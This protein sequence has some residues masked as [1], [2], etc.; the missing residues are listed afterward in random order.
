MTPEEAR[1]YGL[2][3]T[4]RAFDQTYEVAGRRFTA[5]A[6]QEIQKM[7]QRPY[8]ALTSQQLSDTLAGQLK[9]TTPAPLDPTPLTTSPY[10]ES[11]SK[12]WAQPIFTS[13]SNVETVFRVGSDGRP[14]AVTKLVDKPM[15]DSVR[16]AGESEIAWLKR[17]VDEMRWEIPW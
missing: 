9:G 14:E 17:R 16:N 2:P 4:Y 1:I 3:V 6:W 15:A 10:F 11:N 5:Q 12:L 7:T 13:S 8:K